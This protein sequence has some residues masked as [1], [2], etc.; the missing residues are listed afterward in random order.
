MLVDS[1]PSP[2]AK[3][4]ASRYPSNLAPVLNPRL[5]K[6]V[7]LNDDDSTTSQSQ[8]HRYP[9]ASS[10][11]KPLSFWKKQVFAIFEQLENAHLSVKDEHGLTH[12]GDKHGPLKAQLTIHTDRVY[13]R[14]ALAGTMGVAES[15]MDGDWECNDL[16]ALFRMFAAQRHLIERLDS[17]LAKCLRPMLKWGERCLANTIKGSRKNIHAH[18][19]LGNDLF[20]LFL[21]RS[22][23]YSSAYFQ[24]PEMSLEQASIAKLE[25][26]CQMVELSEKDHLLE[27][28]TGWGSLA[29]H[30]AKSR[31]CRV[32]T[33]TLSTEQ[34]AMAE[35]RIREQGLQNLIDVQLL[36]YRNIDGVYDKIISIEMIEAVGH[37]YLATYFQKI[38]ALLKTG[39]LCAI[40]AITVPDQHHAEHLKN[41]DFIQKY[42]FPGS[43]IPSIAS[44]LSACQGQTQLVLTDVKDLSQDYARTMMIWNDSFEQ[45]ISE[46]QNLGYD[47]RFIRMWRYYLQYCAAGFRERYLGTVQCQWRKV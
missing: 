39:G 8:Q 29:I 14:F 37:Q 25:R 32:T 10:S 20:E 17:G 30:A 43:K 47:E 31:G 11:N 19:D 22:L 4:F 15:Y 33:V 26:M 41:V 40:Q 6:H 27:I 42:I 9:K 34:K 36:D 2:V 23:T 46:V 24:H 13:R 35:Q 7:H 16:Y 44:M 5:S 38:N 1:R 3:K 18:Y 28:G 12:F 45:K 21:D